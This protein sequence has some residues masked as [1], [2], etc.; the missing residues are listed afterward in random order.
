[1]F[2]LWFCPNLTVANHKKNFARD[3]LFVQLEHKLGQRKFTSFW[4]F[5]QAKLEMSDANNT[6]SQSSVVSV[7]LFI[8][9]KKKADKNTFMFRSIDPLSIKILPQGLPNMRR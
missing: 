9:L 6:G 4:S 3:F 8:V 7:F 2:I 5:L 1:M